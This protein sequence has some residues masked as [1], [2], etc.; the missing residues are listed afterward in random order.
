MA[1]QKLTNLAAETSPTDDDLLYTVDNPAATPTS[2]KITWTTVKA[3]LKTYFDG[4]YSSKRY[5]QMVIF[6]FETDVATGD[7]KFYFHVP[8]DFDGMNLIEV[9]AEVI[10]AGTTGTTD[11]QIHNATDAVDMLSTEITIDSAESGSDTAAT[12]AVIDTTKDDVVENDLLRVD[13][14]AVSTTAPKGLI[15]T[16]GFKTP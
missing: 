11:I 8:A 9:H 6:D 7:G 16:L 3:F 4:I 12:P 14:D 13:V 10:T 2:K 1:D 15:V 5:A